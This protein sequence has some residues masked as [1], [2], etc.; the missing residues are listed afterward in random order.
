MVRSMF[1][2]N[3]FMHEISL[4]QIKCFIFGLS[5]NISLLNI[6]KRLSQKFGN[7]FSL[8][9]TYFFVTRPVVIIILDHQFIS[10]LPLESMN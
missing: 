6:S 5:R 10:S 7:Y 1:Y 4:S 3:V 2:T 8:I 9:E